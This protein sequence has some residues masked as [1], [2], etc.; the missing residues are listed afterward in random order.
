MGQTLETKKENV[1][2][3]NNDTGKYYLGKKLPKGIWH[4]GNDIFRVRLSRTIYGERRDFCET[5]RGLFEAKEQAMLNLKH[6][7]FYPEY[8]EHLLHLP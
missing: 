1:M 4:L 3:G 8:D 7:S 5:V 6:Q 2:T